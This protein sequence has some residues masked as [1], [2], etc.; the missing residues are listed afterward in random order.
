ML[1]FV[2]NS[3]SVILLLLSVTIPLLLIYSVAIEAAAVQPVSPSIKYSARSLLTLPPVS[4]TSPSHPSLPHFHPSLLYH[5]PCLNIFTLSLPPPFS[6]S[7]ISLLTPCSPHTL[8]S[9]PSILSLPQFSLKCEIF[10]CKM[11]FGK[12]RKTN[13]MCQLGKFQNSWKHRETI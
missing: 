4:N 10:S 1:F 9:H 12:R 8:F 3:P 11:L 7:L 13:S 6:P 2:Y 5:S